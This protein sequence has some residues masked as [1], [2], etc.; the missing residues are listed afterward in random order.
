MDSKPELQTP[1][2]MDESALDAPLLQVTHDEEAHPSSPTPG[3]AAATPTDAH[4]TIEVLDQVTRGE[5]QPNQYRDAVFALL[6]VG[7]LAAVSFCAFAWGVPAI[8]AGISRGGEDHHH[9][10]NNNDDGSMEHFSLAGILGLCLLSTLAAGGIIFGALGV[11]I[12]YAE[13][14]IQGS[15]LIWIGFT[16]LFGIAFAVKG[17]VWI[18]VIYF[19]IFLLGVWYAYSAWHRI[20]FA[21]ANLVTATTAIKSNLGV[22][23]VAFGMVVALVVWVFLWTLSMMGVYMRTRTCDDTGECNE[24]ATGQIVGLLLLLSFYWTSEVITV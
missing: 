15:L 5:K 17:L 22:M 19:V 3:D 16:L 21:R 23:A 18:S 1:I 8:R 4:A 24:G 7:H 20:P 12:R 6:F 2:M 10:N 13:Q 14:L 9:S 11:M